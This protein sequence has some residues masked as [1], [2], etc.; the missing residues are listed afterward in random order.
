[1][2][3]K[4]WLPFQIGTVLCIFVLSFWWYLDKQRNTTLRNIVDL[5]AEELSS[6][7]EADIRHRIPALQRIVHRWNS[8]GGT[9]KAEFYH[10][11]NNY[12]ED[13]PGFQ[14]LE[15]V[16]KKFYVRWIIPLAGNEQAQDLNLAFEKNRR[17]ALEAARDLA[18]PTMTAPINLVQ[19]NKGFLIYIPIFIDNN[20][21]GFLLAVFKIEQ[22]L[23][24]VF[25][26]N[27]SEI[28][29]KDFNIAVTLNNEQVYMQNQDKPQY[30]DWKS[31]SNIHILNQTAAVSVLP[32]EHFFKKNSSL[33]PEIVAVTGITFSIL[34]ST[35]IFLLQKTKAATIQA[36]KANQAKSD[37]LSSMSH[38]LRTPLNSIMGFS[39][40]IELTSKEDLSKDHA[41]EIINAGNHLLALINELLDLAKIESGA[42]ELSIESHDLNELLE[43]CLSTLTPMIEE[44]SIQ[45][46]NKLNLS[47]TFHIN[48]DGV[49]FKQAVFNILS[50]A[51]KYNNDNGEISI[52][53]SLVENNM[54]CLSITD[55]GAGL[56]LEQQRYLFNRFERIGHSDIE[57]EGT[58]LGLA[59]SKD[60]IEMMGGSV[61]VESDIGK[62]SR[63]W[64]QVPL[65]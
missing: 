24:Y 65:S 53:C 9:S 54:L 4:T 17:I 61:G 50:N 1:M 28:I 29:S 36:R 63:F 15:W 21:E 43:A 7:I 34:F 49:K 26:L 5:R 27:M 32:T 60:L 48:V 37:F 31:I 41:A 3:N 16:D 30:L 47:E 51:I 33:I 20:F 12:I 38:E 8:Q 58:G 40:L 46:N 25:S 18:V 42:V 39:Q 52:K 62:G 23:D 55:T 22:W 11:A 59:I 64:I 19:G 6:Y 2:E 14:A 13:L 35:L 44:K 56:T 10:D 57:V 45:I